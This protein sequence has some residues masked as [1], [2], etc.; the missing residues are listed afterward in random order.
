M[1]EYQNDSEDLRDMKMKEIFEWNKVSRRQHLEDSET[2]IRE[3]NGE[4][5][6]MNC[7]QR[8]LMI[9]STGVRL[10]TIML[11]KQS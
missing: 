8:L 6:L 10:K 4:K 11:Q 5:R 9:Q 7:L 1:G 3:E 2:K